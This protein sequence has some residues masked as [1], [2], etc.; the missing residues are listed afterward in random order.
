MTKCHH[1]S[2]RCSCLSWPGRSGKRRV[3][4]R[5]HGSSFAR[6][7]AGITLDGARRLW[8]PRRRRPRAAGRCR[9][10]TTRRRRPPVP[11][12]ANCW[13]AVN[14]N[15]SPTPAPA[16]TAT[17]R[18]DTRESSSCPASLADTRHGSHRVGRRP[19]QLPPARRQGRRQRRQVRT[20]KREGCC[21]PG[22]LCWPGDWLFANGAVVVAVGVPVIF[23]I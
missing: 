4:G 11:G 6:A 16:T 2:L 3:I 8:P 5:E 17:Q 7:S 22:F 13:G 21:A 23:G 20:S 18:V 1:P 14:V 19:R 12:R 10:A 9:R 15:T